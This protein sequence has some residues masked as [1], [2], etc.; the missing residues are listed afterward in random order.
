MDELLRLAVVGHTNV[1]KTSLL[2]TLARRADFG[3]VADRAGT[4][5]HVEQLRLS[6]DGA[7]ELQLLD[8]PGLEDAPGLLQL[9]QQGEGWPHERIARFLA[10]PQAQGDFEQEAKVLRALQQVDAALIVIDAREPVLPKHR[11]ELQLLSWCGRPLMPVLNHLR[12]ADGH[13]PDWLRALAEHGLHVLARFDAVA[14]FVGAE[15]QLLQDLQS[16]L[17]ERGP[18]LQRLRQ[19]LQREARQRREAACTVLARLLLRGAALREL[20]QRSELDTAPARSAAAAG[21]R[22]RLLDL[23]GPSV[24]QLLAIYGFRPGDADAQLLPW[25]DGRRL[26]TLFEPEALKAAGTALG[27]GAATGAAIGLV[28]D[29]ALAGLSLGTATALGAAIGGTLSQGFTVAGRALRQGL[30]GQ[31]ELGVEETVLLLLADQLLGLLLQLEQRGHA[32]QQAL[33]L[34]PP[35][36]AARSLQAALGGLLGRARAYPHWAEAPLSQLED[37]ARWRELQQQA[38]RQ[39]LA[40]LDERL[41]GAETA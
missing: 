41:T 13:E 19:A 11:A 20:R 15:Q 7:P 35:R 40:Q 14:P 25:L 33:R 26:Q 23:A 37:E 29:L 39:C 30:R 8:T 6:L 27:R 10:G 22:R 36:E 38:A 34:A 16:L 9:L 4:T 28:A 5:R 24:D 2:R 1:G 3:E 21:L 17:R 31:V 32:A 12:A 18:A